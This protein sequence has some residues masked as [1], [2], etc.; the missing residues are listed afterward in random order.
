MN[1]DM[2]EA[3][4][5]AICFHPQMDEYGDR[6]A[7]CHCRRPE[8]C[9]AL[10]PDSDERRDLIRQAEAAIRATLE[11]LREPDP[12]MIEAGNRALGVGMVNADNAFAAMIDAVL[13]EI[14]EGAPP[15]ATEGS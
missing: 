7:H 8:D 2:I 6:Y 10:W 5:R 9:V 11:A 13:E 1:Y 15:K 3:V 12:N 14:A 4:A